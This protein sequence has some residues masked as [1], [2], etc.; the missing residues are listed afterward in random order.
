VST[1]W[2]RLGR[3]PWVTS[4]L[5]WSVPA[6]LASIHT[7]WWNPLIGRP[8]SFVRA[9]LSEAPPWYVLALISPPLL[10]ML[11]RRMGRRRSLREWMAPAALLVLAASVVL[12]VF[13][14]AYVSRQP[15]RSLGAFLRVLPHAAT[16]FLPAMLLSFVVLDRQA[17]ALARAREAERAERSRAELALELA[18]AQVRAI[19]GQ[20]HPHFLFNTLDSVVALLR[21]GQTATAIRATVLLSELLRSLLAWRGRTLVSL[22]SELALVR[23]YVELEQL[24]FADRLHVD[25]RVEP[26]VLDALVPPLLLQP[27]VEN[28]VRHGVQRRA[29]AGLLRIGGRE[30]AGELE[31]WVEDDGPGP[32]AAALNGGGTGLG[33]SATRERVARMFGEGATV[34]LSAR[35]EGGAHARVRLPLTR[36][37]LPIR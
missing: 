5:F 23:K 12:C 15:D 11:E 7:W 28:A 21:E 27:L 4:L 9:F 33:L 6:L 26:S 19:E 22:D 3:S 30:L 35:P 32:S 37:A 2:H 18:A 25:W 31:L 17:R 13:A 29:R 24:R 8:I 14:M 10:A 1:L 34:E 20:L 36:Q 16:S